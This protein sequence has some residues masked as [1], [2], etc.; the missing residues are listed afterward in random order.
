MIYNSLI[1]TMVQNQYGCNGNP[2]WRI[3]AVNHSNVG[4]TL[5]ARITGTP[6]DSIA[7]KSGSTSYVQLSNQGPSIHDIVDS[8]AAN[9]CQIYDVW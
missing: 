1:N 9:E 5:S 2:D 4:V 7:Y 8:L 3:F 6:P